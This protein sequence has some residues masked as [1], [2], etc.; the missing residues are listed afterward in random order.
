MTASSQELHRVMVV[1][2]SLLARAVVI[3][4]LKNMR[5]VEVAEACDGREALDRLSEGDWS[6]LVCAYEMPGLGGL[7]LLRLLRET[8]SRNDL[9]VLILTGRGSDEYKA[10][11]LEAGANDYI[12][13]PFE[14][15]E[16]R[17]RVRLQL[18][19]LDLQRQV[20]ARR[21][22]ENQL[23]GQK[24]ETLGQ[25]AA[26]I[27]HEINTPLQ[28][29]GD[30]TEFVRSG[31]EDVLRLLASYRDRLR[32]YESSQSASL[33]E[34]GEIEDESDLSYLVRELP[35]AVAQSMDGLLRVSDI[36]GAMKLLAHPGSK[37]P[38]PIDINEFLK[39]TVT[40]ARN[41]WKHVAEVHFDLEGGLPTVIAHPGDL[42]QALLN[43]LVNAAHAVADL[44][45]QRPG[46]EKSNIQI[47]T[48]RRGS[49]IE[50]RVSDD[51]PGMPEEVRR[52]IL[53]PFF[54]TREMGH[55]LGHGLAIARVTI[56]DRC[57]GAIEVE[58]EEGVGTT[59]VVSLP[60]EPDA[61]ERHWH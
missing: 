38:F 55:G 28:F 22:R 34:L 60:L 6:L 35:V 18:E 31:L 61:G 15:E 4:A 21:E 10:K 27:A 25:L 7:G 41:E 2:N 40:V 17:Q 33:R 51:G 12:A 23:Q 16:L 36:V 19:V 8:K 52:R 49:S 26:G 9:P 50:I 29:V 39:S 20:V 44:V 47:S 45:A 56:E 1:D 59:I 58:S 30:N 46:G 48:K 14:P 5:C 37:D 54:A 57:G 13:R 42:S 24:L 32:V 11:L 53:E 3:C 43:I